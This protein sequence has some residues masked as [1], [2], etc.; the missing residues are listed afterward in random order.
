MMTCIDR[1]TGGM[2]RKVLLKIVKPYPA[3]KMIFN[4]GNIFLNVSSLAPEHYQLS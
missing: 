3:V 4:P 1:L 2:I